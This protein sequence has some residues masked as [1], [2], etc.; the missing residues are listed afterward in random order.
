[1]LEASK[2]AE[3]DSQHSSTE[4]GKQSEKPPNDSTPNSLI[5]EEN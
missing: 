2:H 5:T 4:L 3:I 1:M